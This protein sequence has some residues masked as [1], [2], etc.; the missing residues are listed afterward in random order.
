M[1]EVK[2][3]TSS[4]MGGGDFTRVDLPNGKVVI[5]WHTCVVDETK[6]VV[7]TFPSAQ[8]HDDNQDGTYTAF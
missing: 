7:E 3:K 5:V 2:V 1:V 4:D 6:S 8:A